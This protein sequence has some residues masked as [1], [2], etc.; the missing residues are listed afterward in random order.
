MSHTIDLRSYARAD[1]GK[2]LVGQGREFDTSQYQNGAVT[3]H[4]LPSFP[5]HIRKRIYDVVCEAKGWVSRADIAKALKLKKTP[6][7][8]EHIEALVA[9]HYLV[10]SHIYRPNGVIMYYYEVKR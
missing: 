10:R 7:L 1:D 6:W 9:E 5:E 2:L 3:Y 8:H 4:P